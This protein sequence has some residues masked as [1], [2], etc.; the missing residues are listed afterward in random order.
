MKEVALITL[1][2]MGEVKKNYFEDL[3]NKLKNNLNDEWNK[4][5]FQNVQYAPLLQTPQNELW[6]D[7]RDSKN[8]NDL[9]FTKLRK[10]FLFGFGDIPQSK[11]CLLFAWVFDF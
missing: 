6:R 1:H 8:N 7:M 10:F 5:S 3:E 2:G 9:D 11:L 4:I